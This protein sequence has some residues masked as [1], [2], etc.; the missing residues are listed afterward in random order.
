MN[1]N[2]SSLVLNHILPAPIQYESYGRSLDSTLYFS[3]PLV[4][5]VDGFIVSVNFRLFSPWV[6]NASLYVF[7]I[8][9]SVTSYNILH[10]HAIDPQRNTTEWQ[11]IHIPSDA[12]LINRGHLVGIG[13][14][15]NSS[16]TSDTNEIHAVKTAFSAIGLNIN[17]NSTIFT[18]IIDDNVSVAFGYNVVYKS[19]RRF[20][21][22]TLSILL[23]RSDEI[24]EANNSSLVRSIRLDRC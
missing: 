19:K 15:E 24:N 14:Q 13:M 3:F 11:T 17:I 23:F 22:Y 5:Q 18:P 16:S 12:L 20:C 2:L 9:F 21:Q 1:S 4:C 8:S 7:I 6:G 10:R